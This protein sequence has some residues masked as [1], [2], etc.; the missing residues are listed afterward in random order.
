MEEQK[1]SQESS[2]LI[3][4]H[5]ESVN[6]QETKDGGADDAEG[7]ISGEEGTDPGEGEGKAG[8][9]KSEASKAD[10][11][12]EVKEEGE[13][14]KEEG[15]SHPDEPKAYSPD[16]SYKYLR[17]SKSLPDELKAVINTP[18]KEAFYKEI[19]TKADG[20]PF[21]KQKRE[22]AEAQLQNYDSLFTDFMK[23]AQLGDFKKAWTD[24]AGLP[25]P[26]LEQV[27]SGFGFTPRDIIQHAYD[28]ANQSPEQA[29][30]MKI[31]SD[32]DR[33][34]AELQ[35]RLDQVEQSQQQQME[36]QIYYEYDQLTQDPG[37]ASIINAFEAKH[38][39]DAFFRE[40]AIRGAQ[41]SQETGRIL[42]P[43][44]IANDIIDRYNLSS[45]VS[46][47]TGQAH[48]NR[49]PSQTAHGNNQ[50]GQPARSTQKEVPVIP[51]ID[52]S[53]GSPGQRS[54]SSI[55]DLEKI[56]QEKFGNA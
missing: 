55:E 23:S 9:E 46:Q 17:E 33:R 34:A 3:Q 40:V 15:E 13:A 26:K 36:Q 47:P 10:E 11:A 14:P 22:Q 2:D 39:K 30:A 45:L 44:A 29:E 35:M 32:A 37:T 24:V 50:S 31:K 52:G 43:R 25:Q 1:E 27:L 19:F 6:S 7:A 48:N 56:Y 41:I 21:M 20:F 4:Q 49:L 28:L 54:I 53:G 12:G 51:A 8:A 18:E 42:S 38:G 5:I 16:L